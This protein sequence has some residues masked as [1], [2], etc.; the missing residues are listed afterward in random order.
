MLLTQKTTM[1]VVAELQKG[2]DLFY[3]KFGLYG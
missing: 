2:K 3:L 1:F